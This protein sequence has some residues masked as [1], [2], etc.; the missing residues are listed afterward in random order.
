MLSSVTFFCRRLG[1]IS[2]VLDMQMKQLNDKKKYREAI[3]L[4]ESSLQQNK[5]STK[6]LFDQ[7]L[8]ACIELKDFQRGIEI[9]SKISSNWMQNLFIRN[10]LIRLHSWLS[11]FKNLILLILNNFS[12]EMW[13]CF[14]SKN[15]L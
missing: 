6:L 12:S 15:S 4:F 11:L 14:Q 7:A 10:R 8:R 9:E 3:E 5:S 2:V 1:S 13:K